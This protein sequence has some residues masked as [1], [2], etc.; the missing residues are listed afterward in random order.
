MPVSEFDLIG[1]ENSEFPHVFPEFLGIE[2]QLM[3][4]FSYISPYTHESV[5]T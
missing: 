4:T 1:T 5:C 2:N 3:S